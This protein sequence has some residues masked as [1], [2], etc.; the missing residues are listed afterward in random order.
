VSFFLPTQLFFCRK[1]ENP[2]RTEKIV[3]TEPSNIEATSDEF[4]VAFQR[5]PMIEFSNLLERLQQIEPGE[6]ESDLL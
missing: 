3:I 6:P 5:R 4:Y 2:D 1:R